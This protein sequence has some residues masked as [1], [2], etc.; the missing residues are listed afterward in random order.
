[1]TDGTGV[2]VYQVDGQGIPG[3]GKGN[4]DALAQF[5]VWVGEKGQNNV[6][7][8]DCP[9]GGYI[10]VT[11]SRATGAEIQ[12]YNFERVPVGPKVTG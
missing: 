7:R 11:G 5:E 10:D 1:M 9:V 8:I 6:H 4:R 12:C 2:G 3:K